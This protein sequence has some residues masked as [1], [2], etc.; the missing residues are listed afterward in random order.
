MHLK[1]L[2]AATCLS[3]LSWVTPAKAQQ[4]AETE[5]EPVLQQLPSHLDQLT[6]P[7]QAREFQKLVQQ[8]EPLLYLFLQMQQS[9]S[10]NLQQQADAQLRQILK[11]PPSLEQQ[12]IQ[13]EVHGKLRLDK[14]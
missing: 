8:Q 3:L 6:S 12:L 4:Q 11:Q 9:Q 14:L 1:I 7:S 2:F 13:E 5:N 10:P